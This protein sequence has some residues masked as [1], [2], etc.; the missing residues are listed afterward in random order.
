MDPGSPKTG[1]TMMIGPLW[2]DRNASSRSRSRLEVRYQIADGIALQLAGGALLY[3]TPEGVAAHQFG[4]SIRANP[5][6]LHLIIGSLQQIRRKCERYSSPVALGKRLQAG[7][8]PPDLPGRRILDRDL[9]SSEVARFQLQF[10][11]YKI[12]AR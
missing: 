2:L 10:Q 4:G 12:D 7:A 9:I 1:S 3:H 8:P 11:N 6:E 5:L